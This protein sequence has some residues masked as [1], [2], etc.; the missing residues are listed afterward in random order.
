MRI[1]SVVCQAKMLNFITI[2]TFFQ[3][4]YADNNVKNNSKWC[5]GSDVFVKSRMLLLLLFC[6]CVLSNGAYFRMYCD[7][8][9]ATSHKVNLSQKRFWRIWNQYLTRSTPQ[10]DNNSTKQYIYVTLYIYRDNFHIYNFHL[11]K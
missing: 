1:G 6:V 4:Y 2:F 7:G 11:V 8:V 9:R 3:S 5:D 10:R